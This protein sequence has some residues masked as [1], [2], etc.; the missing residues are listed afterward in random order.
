MVLLQIREDALLH[1]LEFV[2]RPTLGDLRCL[3]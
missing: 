2:Q 3:L 1:V